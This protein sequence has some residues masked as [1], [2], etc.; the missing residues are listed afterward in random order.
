MLT[1]VHIGQ[2]NAE[3]SIAMQ[4]LCPLLKSGFQAFECDS[5]VYHVHDGRRTSGSRSATV[6][7]AE[8]AGRGAQLPFV[9]TPGEPGAVGVRTMEFCVT[10]VCRV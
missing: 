3:V 1:T 2:V 6:R 5:A 9:E 4:A 7:T 10:H 8:D